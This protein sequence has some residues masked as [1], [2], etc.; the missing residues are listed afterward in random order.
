MPERPHLMPRRTAGAGVT[1][2]PGGWRFEM[3]AG[4]RGTYRLAQ[5]DD[6]AALT[7]R[8][9]PWSAPLTVSLRA[10]LSASDLPGTWGFGLWNDPFGLSIGFGGTAGRLPN[11]PQAAWFFHGSSENYLSLRDDLPARGFFAG[12]LRSPRLPSL[13]LAPGLLALPFLALRPVSR[14]LRRLGARIVGEAAAPMLVDVTNWHQYTFTWLREG[15]QFKVDSQLLL[16]TPI[17]PRGPLG[18]VLWID[19]QYAAWAP[20]GGLRYGTLANPPAWMEISNLEV[21]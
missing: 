20:D 1:P 4:R 3:P 19:N 5:L 18:L 8:R 15:V 11:L 10:R 21:G 13:V 7:R 12:A 14:R 2:I 6:Y 9:L 16:E 17:S